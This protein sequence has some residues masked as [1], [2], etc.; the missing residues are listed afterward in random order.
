MIIIPCFILNPVSALDTNISKST[1]G[2]RAD[3]GRDNVLLSI[4]QITALP[5]G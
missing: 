2:P 5:G 3:K 4:H 1:E